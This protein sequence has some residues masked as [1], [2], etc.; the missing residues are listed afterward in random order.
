MPTPQQDREVQRP[1]GHQ[2]SWSQE[3]V[4]EVLEPFEQYCIV[5]G[6]ENKKICSLNLFVFTD[7]LVTLH[8][9]PALIYP[10]TL[11]ILDIPFN[12]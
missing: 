10:S 4:P 7:D 9:H 3:A 8:K 11:Y 5:C 12:T 6:K 1:E 2:G